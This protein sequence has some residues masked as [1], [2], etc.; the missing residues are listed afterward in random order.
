MEGKTMN[1]V[2]TGVDWG[3]VEKQGEA[4]DAFCRGLLTPDP[5]RVRWHFGKWDTNPSGSI[6]LSASADFDGV[7]VS[8][9]RYN[10]NKHTDFVSLFVGDHHTGVELCQFLQ[11]PDRAEIDAAIRTIVKMHRAACQAGGI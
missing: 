1:T 8:V 10:G 9:H 6:S 3:A 2:E 11:A 5:E 7:T 4:M